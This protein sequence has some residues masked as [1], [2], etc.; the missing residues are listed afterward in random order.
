M[1]IQG[2]QVPIGSF[3]TVYWEF[4]YGLLGV[5]VRSIGSGIDKIPNVL[6]SFLKLEKSYKKTVLKVPVGG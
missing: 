1:R 4:W 2:S 6:Y 5:L 3:G